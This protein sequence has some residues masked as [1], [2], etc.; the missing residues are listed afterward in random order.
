MK[1][2]RLVDLSARIPL[3]G[4][5]VPSDSPVSLQL[6][7]DQLDAAKLAAALGKTFPVQGLL[8]AKGNFAGTLETLTGSLTAEA[9][10]IKPTAAGGPPTEPAAVKLTAL[11]KEGNL[12]LDGTAT[13][14]PLQPAKPPSAAVLSRPL[15]R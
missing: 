11:V 15:K 2:E 7:I 3:K 14:R 1:N 5:K 9:T 4:G 12:T 8:S 13:Q 10:R 6:E